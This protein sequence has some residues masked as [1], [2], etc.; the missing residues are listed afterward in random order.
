MMCHAGLSGRL[1]GWSIDA[2]DRAVQV[3]AKTVSASPAMRQ[4][5]IVA[6]LFN[7]GSDVRIKPLQG[8]GSA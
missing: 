6:Q 7:E 2:V 5:A 4:V 1:G 8:M 3:L